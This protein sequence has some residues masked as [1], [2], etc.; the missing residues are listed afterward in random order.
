MK[1][2]FCIKLLC[3]LSVLL[4]INEAYST[5]IQ[6][7]KA[8]KPS[9]PAK[10]STIRAYTESERWTYYGG[11]EFNDNE[12]DTSKWSLYDNNNTYGQPQGMIQFYN[13][14]Q[15]SETTDS[16]GNGVLVITSKR[17]KGKTITTPDGASYEAWNSGFITSGGRYAPKPTK[18]FAERSEERRV[19]KEC[20]SRWSPYH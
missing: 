12:I 17:M 11:D 20:R 3:L 16:Q 7:K 15:V 5:T 14:S 4:S 1:K 6:N 10:N 9:P 8:V 18:V 19:G 13:A 2:F